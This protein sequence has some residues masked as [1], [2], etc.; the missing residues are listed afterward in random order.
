MIRR[1]RS[2][3]LALFVFA[4]LFVTVGSSVG[5]PGASRPQSAEFPRDLS[6]GDRQALRAGN[7]FG[8]EVLRRLHAERLDYRANVFISPLSLSLSLGMLL[9]GAGGETF[10][11]MG[12]A[13]GLNGLMVAEANEAY[14][15]LAESLVRSDP[16]VQFQLANNSWIEEG[17][18]IRRDYQSRVQET[19][20]ARV[21]AARFKEPGMAGAINGWVDMATQGRVTD[22]VS[23]DAFAGMVALVVN[24]TYFRAEWTDPFDPSQTETEDFQRAD[25][26]MVS[27]PMMWQDL[28]ARVG[29]GEGS[30]ED[31]VA[32]DLPYGG[33]SFSMTL[34]VPIGDETLDGML[35]D[36]D[37]DRW[38]DVLDALRGEERTEVQIPRFELTYE[39]ELNDVLKAMGMEVAFDQSSADFGWLLGDA[40]QGAGTHIGRMKQKSFVRVDERGTETAAATGTAV[41]AGGTPALSAD[42]PFL[43]AI[44]E[45]ESGA[46]IFVGTV[47][48]PTG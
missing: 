36:M 38:Q 9:N 14:R 33:R 40:G 15:V 11:A 46:I 8:F 25:G 24:T 42:R 26:S 17:Y 22:M 29:G 3:A 39:T 41:A 35:E 19:F 16:S 4:V 31:F 27:V 34:V 30:G 28:D 45:R 7:D 47:S 1:A 48:D 23:P 13:L 6:A 5:S 43:F 12:D 32:V 2:G 20:G 18:R 44:R 10:N 37:G 21:Q